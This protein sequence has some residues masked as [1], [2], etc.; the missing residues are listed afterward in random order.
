MI[1]CYLN[2]DIGFSTIA[3]KLENRLVFNEFLILF[4]VLVKLLF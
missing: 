2:R 3:T 1:Q 4:I